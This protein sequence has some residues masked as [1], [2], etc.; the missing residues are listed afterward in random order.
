MVHYNYCIL[1]WNIP[2]HSGKAIACLLCV[3]KV[4]FII[5]VYTQ[6]VIYLLA[7]ELQM[8]FQDVAFLSS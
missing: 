1:S 8:G 2:I 6:F 5:V 3:N 7:G 4:A